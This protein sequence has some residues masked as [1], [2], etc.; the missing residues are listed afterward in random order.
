[1]QRAQYVDERAM[2]RCQRS[3]G[4]TMNTTPSSRV[5][6][7]LVLAI[8]L[9]TISAPIIHAQPND[10]V[11]DR[12]FA[13]SYEEPPVAAFDWTASY[14]SLFFVDRS[15]H[16]AGP[17]GAW[18]WDFGDGSTSTQPSV[19]LH[20]YSSAGTYPA[21]LTV[22]DANNGETGSITK[23]VVVPDEA[24]GLP[25]T[26][27]I[28]DFKAYDEVGGHSDFE[29][30]NNGLVTGLAN[31]N[32]TPGG[33][34]SLRSTTGSG[35][36]PSITSASSFAQWFTDDLI[37]KPIQH[38]VTLTQT[39][40]NVYDYQ[41]VDYFPIDGEGFGNYQPYMNG[42]H[43]YHFTTMLHAAF[44]YLSNASPTFTFEGNDDAWLYI[45]GRLAIDIGGVHGSTAG[46]VTLN[47]TMATTLNLTNGAIIRFDL[48]AAN[49]HTSDS[50]FHLTVSGT[51]LSDAN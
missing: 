31:T 37:N 23:S 16:P 1:V 14:H 36:A 5:R 15:T 18:L 49:R 19:I 7:A 9:F 34:P 25:L 39:S 40:P 24:C 28:H 2:I 3:L 50:Q 4:R 45:N 10:A 8:A 42:L 29:Q 41:D 17:I 21:T 43:N 20:T 46:S 48:F 35:G 11:T 32:M 33:V 38:T 13:D 26:L 51:C 44:Q 6:R 30:Y 12:V 27:R 22:V 47:A